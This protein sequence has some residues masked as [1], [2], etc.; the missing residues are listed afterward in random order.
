M[1]SIFEVLHVSPLKIE[2]RHDYEKRE[3]AK[4]KLLQVHDSAGTRLEK[5]LRLDGDLE[6]SVVRSTNWNP[7]FENILQELKEKLDK[8]ERDLKLQILTIVVGHLKTAEMI[9]IFKTSRSMV[10]CAADLKAKNGILALPDRKIGLWVILLHR[11]SSTK[12][13]AAWTLKYFE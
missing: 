11:W 1:E 12:N 13:I 6:I 4:R 8:S 9:R 2:K 7:K 10:E 5:T 3:Y